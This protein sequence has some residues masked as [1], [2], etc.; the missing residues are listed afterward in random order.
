VVIIIENKIMTKTKY[1]S[2]IAVLSVL[3]FLSETNAYADVA[4]DPI[5]VG[6]V[7]LLIVGIIIGVVALITWLI[8]RTV[9]RKKNVANK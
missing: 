9:R 7:L 5:A 6:G 8:I 2:V 4:A 3:L 1:V